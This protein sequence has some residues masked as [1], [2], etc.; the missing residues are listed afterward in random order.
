MKYGSVDIRS[1]SNRSALGLAVTWTFY[2]SYV[3]R[4]VDGQQQTAD[5]Q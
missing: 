2:G 1:I 5:P 4:C 3:L